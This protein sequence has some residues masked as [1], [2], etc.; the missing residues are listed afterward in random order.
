VLELLLDILGSN[1]NSSNPLDDGH[2]LAGLVAALGQLRLRNTVELA[3]VR[4]QFCND[5]LCAV[6]LVL[7]SEQPSGITILRQS[8]AVWV[9]KVCGCKGVWM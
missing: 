7:Q 2:W 4:L 8:F 6:V 5:T 3:K 9:A 1:D